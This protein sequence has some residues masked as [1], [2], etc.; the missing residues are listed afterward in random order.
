[1]NDYFCIKYLSIYIF[2]IDNSF[3]L[4]IFVLC[5]NNVTFPQEIVPYFIIRLGFYQQLL[6]HSPFYLMH[7]LMWSEI[8]IYKFEFCFK[9][10]WVKLQKFNYKN[11]FHVMDS[12][13]C[14]STQCH[15]L[16]IYRRKFIEIYRG[17]CCIRGN[18]GIHY[19][20]YYLSC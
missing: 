16:K 13:M 14:F 5:M 19:Y 18:I 15:M 20:Y 6:F 17:R 2:Q 7:C 4:V 8:F 12:Y 1:M 11:K 9:L 3:K 10:V